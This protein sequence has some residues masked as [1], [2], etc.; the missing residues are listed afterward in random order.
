MRDTRRYESVHESPDR[1]EAYEEALEAKEGIPF[2][3]D[4]A[5]ISLE[6]VFA[7]GEGKQ[8]WIWRAT[9]TASRT[10]F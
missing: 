5:M 7:P 4:E 1:Q 3:P 10:E 6:Q 9:V 8:E 2:T